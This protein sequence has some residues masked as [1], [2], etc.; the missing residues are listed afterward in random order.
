MSQFE[1]CIDYYGWTEKT[2]TIRL[3][4]SIVGDARKTLGTV[5][6]N[7]WTYN[8]LKKHMEVRYGKS[9]VYAQIQTELLTHTRNPGQGCTIITTK[10]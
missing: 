6:A 1:A 2:K 10:L 7:N 4:T 3:Y 8:Q 5:S 9:K